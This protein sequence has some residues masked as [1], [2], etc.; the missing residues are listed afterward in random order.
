MKRTSS[1]LMVIA[2]LVTSLVP[3][4]TIGISADLTA[5]DY[6]AT[7]DPTGAVASFVKDDTTY[8][9]TSLE[10][11]FAFGGT[12]GIDNIDIVAQTITLTSATTVTAKGSF[13]LDGNGCKITDSSLTGGTLLKIMGTDINTQVTLENL[14]LELVQKSANVSTFE[15][16]NEVGKNGINN[17]TPVTVCLKNVTINEKAKA[18][19]TIGVR[20]GT[21]LILDNGTVISNT[22]S[23]KNTWS[24]EPIYALF[25]QSNAIVEMRDGA[26]INGL[27]VGI[28]AKSGA[29]AS[30]IIISGGTVAADGNQ[31][32]NTVG[33]ATISGG[34][35]TATNAKAFVTTNNATI[36]GGTFT[37]TCALGVEGGTTTVSDGTFIATTEACVNSTKGGNTIINGGYF[38][39][40][41]SSLLSSASW[42]W[43]LLTAGNGTGYKGGTI[44][45]N[46]GIFY[47]PAGGRIYY[48]AAS[49][50][51]ASKV[52]VNSCTIYG[53]YN[54]TDGINLGGLP[55]TEEGAAVRTVV[56]QE[57]IR[58][59]STI[60]NNVISK[61]NEAKKAGTA[62]TY[63]TVIAPAE[64]VTAAGLFTMKSLDKAN[65][66]V[67][68]DKRYVNIVAKDGIQTDAS[69]NVSFCAA[70]VNLNENNYTRDF[71]A[72]AYISY[73]TENGTVIIYGGFDAD[74]NVRNM[75]EVAYA[76]LNDVKGEKE[77]GYATEVSEWYEY[78]TN[79]A[80]WEKKTGTAYSC[81]STAQ[82]EAIKKYIAE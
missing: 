71:A 35:I 51:S 32:I 42:G 61:A 64:Y 76:A 66:N 6:T 79:E 50:D 14:T 23:A 7:T 45:V 65:L 11:V 24:S 2:I 39:T 21:K 5:D 68:A 48:A 19:N 34:T 69:G 36:S 75:E 82:L 29:E 10:A 25:V 59:K 44:T 22:Y 13:T 63:G 17:P 1:I 78:N 18:Y 26:S 20:A 62:V 54:V 58:F 31:A 37:G 12:E 4:M 8:Y 81:Y 3:M 74:K 56:D 53:S 43:G 33:T 16:G 55:A 46:D 27:G 30:N 80:K 9:V 41:T 72:I 57:G 28:Y 60:S 67:A 70:L 52:T 38:T 47:Y 77:T 49:S 73:E 40:K 15:V